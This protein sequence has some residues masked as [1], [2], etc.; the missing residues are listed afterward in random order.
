M[1]EQPLPSVTVSVM[2]APDVIPLIDHILPKVLTTVPEVLINV[3]ELTVIPTEY[4]DKSA[5]HAAAVVT[6]IT[7]KALTVMVLVALLLQP[8]PSVYV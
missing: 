4:V 5:A 2:S 7:G 6:V 8:E 1:F 3:P